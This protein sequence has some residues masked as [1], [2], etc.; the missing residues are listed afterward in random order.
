MNTWKSKRLNRWKQTRQKGRG[1]YVLKTTLIA[2]GSVLIGKTAG[3]ILFDKVR[4]W[5]EFW[6]DFGFSTLALLVIG[7]ILGIATWSV[8]ESWY[9]REVNRQERT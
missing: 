4:S 9:K 3:F 2:G 7:V 1:H 6:F 5:S 8:S